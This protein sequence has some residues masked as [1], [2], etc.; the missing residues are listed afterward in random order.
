MARTLDS[1]IE[2]NLLEKFSITFDD[3]V[4]FLFKTKYQFFVCE[5]TIHKQKR[6]TIKT[7]DDLS[8]LVIMYTKNKEDEWTFTSLYVY[9][10][11]E[12]A[13]DTLISNC[14]LNTLNCGQYKHIRRYDGERVYII[15]NRNKT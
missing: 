3:L 7:N 12:S 10:C 2:E 14:V 4:K 5:D 1:V 8:V 6:I 15:P 13:Y 11:T 9:Q